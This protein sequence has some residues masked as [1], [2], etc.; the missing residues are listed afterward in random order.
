MAGFESSV[1]V[2]PIFVSA[3]FLMLATMNPTS[4]AWSC[5]ISTGL[6]VRTPS[7]SASKVV[8]FHI[9]RIRWFFRRCSLEDASQNDHAAIRVEPGIEDER[10]KAIFG[11]SLGRRYA[12]HH[13]FKHVG[14][15]ESGLGAD[16]DGVG[17]VEADRAFDHFLGARN[18][19][20]LK[21]DLVDDWDD[22]KS[23]IDGQIRI[24]ERLG[25]DTLRSVD[26]EQGSFTG[27]EGTG[28]FVRKIDVAGSID[29]VELVS[30]PVLR[31]VHHANGVSLDGDA[32]LAF[33]V[34]RI[35]DLGLHFARGQR[36]GELKK[37]VGQRGFAVVDVSDD[38]EIADERCVH[39]R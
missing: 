34:H 15:A 36:S 7:V 33:E 5:S 21:I 32:A 27:R 37:A 12:L 38:R 19:G 17:G 13:S 28:N 2:S 23:V 29:E 39:E 22:F 14:H 30:F 6:G 1:M 10:L 24:R 35:K 8:P 26:D 20:A 9:S 11:Q 3:T 16:E 25:F 31:G 4:P 18:V